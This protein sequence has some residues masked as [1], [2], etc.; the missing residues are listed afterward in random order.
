MPESQSGSEAPAPEVLKP[1]DDSAT[2][3]EPEESSSAAAQGG[4]AAKVEKKRRLTYRPSHRATFIGIGV[5]LA[6]LAINAGVV[7]FFIQSQA[8]DDSQVQRDQVTISTEALEKLG[9]NKTA[10]GNLGTQLVVGPDSRFNGTLEVAGD[11]NISGQL[12][13]NNK[14]SAA[15][16][17]LTKLQAGDVAVSLLNVNGD[18]TATNLALRS[19]LAVAGTTEMQGAVMVSN[20]MNVIG[21]LTV[22]GSL[23]AGSFQ[24][25]NLVAGS[26]LTLGGH[27]V[28]KGVAPGVSAGGG[29]GSN[30]TVSISGTDTAGT[31]AVNVGTGGGNGVLAN[32]D[33][34][35][36]FA[37]TPHVMVT[38][39]GRSA[40]SIYVNR[41]STG[42][43]ISV[44]NA[45]SAGGYA[46]DY[47]IVQ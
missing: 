41:T 39:V 19:N 5:V 38:A 7:F 13:L 34:H 1:Q 43:S 3:P 8:K 17:S 47:V 29:V 24:A 42:F 23:F 37:D 33:F 2:I 46:F 11:T 12:T 28:T 44:G 31:V 32:I 26:T 22:G 15:D 25:A 18:A 40:G 9:V 45:L 35:D 21:N 4:A 20:N 10:V 6:V 16:A 14:L 27:V 30:G 36:N